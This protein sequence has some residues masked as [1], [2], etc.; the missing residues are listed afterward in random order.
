[1]PRDPLLYR[2][3][4]PFAW[5]HSF[6]CVV[7]LVAVGGWLATVS[8]VL[9]LVLLC[10]S[11]TGFCGQPTVGRAAAGSVA[12]GTDAGSETVLFSPPHASSQYVTGGR[13]QLFLA[14]TV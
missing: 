9:R 1:M 7:G 6:G 11:S 4:C 3:V 13:D 5:I 10:T 2:Y 8:G 12:T 14:D